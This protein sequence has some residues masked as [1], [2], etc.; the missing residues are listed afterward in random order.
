MR[1]TRNLK[2]LSAA[3]LIAA[4]CATDARADG[5]V[6]PLVG[7]NFGGAA[8]GTF[9][10]NVRD[11]NHTTFGADVGFMSGGLFGVELDVAFT[12]NFYGHG[13]GIRDNS[14]LT[15]MPSLIVGIPVGGQQGLG[16]RPFGTAGIGMMRR[17]L[18]IDGVEVFDESNLAYSLGFGVMGYFSDHVGLRADYK[19]F[20]NVEVDEVRLTNV[21]FRRGTFD[22]SRAALG[23]LF[24][25]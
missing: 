7:V 15:V 1:T 22:F 10:N 25:F 24:R 12:D 18:N 13:E 2:A 16:I 6:S 4:G 20:R 21:D 17:E 8:G 14:L 3:L 23:I 19:Y 5:F 11:R 9:N